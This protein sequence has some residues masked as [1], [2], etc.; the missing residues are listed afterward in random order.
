[1]AVLGKLLAQE[2]QTI[3]SLPN[4]KIFFPPRNIWKEKE[5]SQIKILFQ[6]YA[7]LNVRVLGIALFNILWICKVSTSFAMYGQKTFAGQSIE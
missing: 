5:D 3:N 7:I 1:M 4:L 2:L 6:S